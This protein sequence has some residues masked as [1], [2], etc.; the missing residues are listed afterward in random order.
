MNSKNPNQPII[1][2][3]AGVVRFKA[4]EIVR[5]LL[6]HGPYDLNTLYV[7]NFSDDDRNQFA[8][9]IGYSVCEFGDLAYADKERVERADKIAAKMRRG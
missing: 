4:N 1:V 3:S 6:D 2:D 7:M 5:V 9:L 8:Q